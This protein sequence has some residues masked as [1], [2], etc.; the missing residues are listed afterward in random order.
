M[1]TNCPTCYHAVKFDPYRE[2]GL[3]KR[4]DY[5]PT[6][7]VPAEQLAEAEANYSL[8]LFYYRFIMAPSTQEFMKAMVNG[9]SENKQ[10]QRKLA[11]AEA[12]LRESESFVDS[13]ERQASLAEKQVEVLAA[14]AKAFLDEA[15]RLW[16]NPNKDAFYTQGKALSDVLADLAAAKERIA[17]GPLVGMADAEVVQYS[18]PEVQSRSIQR[19]LAHQRGEPIPT[20]VLDESVPAADV[21]A[22]ME[23]LRPFARNGWTD[24]AG[25]ELTDDEVVQVRHKVGHFRRVCAALDRPAIRK[26]MEASDASGD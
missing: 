16:R 24:V 14:R 18:Q 26:L 21:R 15:Y 7:C 10:S 1:T 22:V 25:R 8:A 11:E 4:H 5:E 6:G 19:R 12:R 20:F 13:W 3:K 2:V 9:Y 23:A 17:H